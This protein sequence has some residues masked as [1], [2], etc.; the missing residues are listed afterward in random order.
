ML[1]PTIQQKKPFQKSES[2]KGFIH[3]SIHSVTVTWSCFTYEQFN[4]V[5]IKGNAIEQCMKLWN[6]YT[7]YLEWY[8]LEWL[9]IYRKC[10]FTI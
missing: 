5:S 9:K 3:F 10:G 4:H 6:K 2:L 7:I 1:T 8:K